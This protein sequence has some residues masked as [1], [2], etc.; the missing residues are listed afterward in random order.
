MCHTFTYENKN[1]SSDI[2][3]LD[4]TLNYRIFIHDTKYY[5]LLPKSLF[6]RI[7]LQYAAGQNFKA[8]HYEN[9]EISVT[10]HQLLNR[11]ASPCVEEE[12]YDFLECVKTSQ[13]KMVGCRPPWDI[14]SP[15]TIPLCQTMEQLQEYEQTD[16]KFFKMKSKNKFI[17]M[18]GCLPPCHYK[19]STIVSASDFSTNDKI[20]S[21]EYRMTENP[22]SGISSFFGNNNSFMFVI[23]FLDI[24]RLEREVQAYP[25]ISFVAEMGGALG[26]FIGVSFLSVL[27]FW[28]YV[29]YKYKQGW[30]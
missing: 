9:N 5:H 23:S 22:K 3:V 13:A 29:F 24:E 12:D 19:V 10:K 25:V 16:L 27:D 21:K 20:T 14:W 26:L 30:K 15:H 4:P 8:G 17:M 18:T 28:E 7:F 2:F 11:P 1:G 6:P